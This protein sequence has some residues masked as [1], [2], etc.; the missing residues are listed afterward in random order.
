MVSCC[1][2]VTQS[3]DAEQ[4]LDAFDAVLRIHPGLTTRLFPAPDTSVDEAVWLQKPTSVGARDVVVQR[5]F[6]ED[7]TH[8][9]I[10][11]E[12]DDIRSHN[13]DPREDLPLRGSVTPVRGGGILVLAAHHL[14]MDAL[15]RLLLVRA[16]DQELRSDVTDPLPPV[17]GIR[18]MV[19]REQAASGQPPPD[20]AIEAVEHVLRSVQPSGIGRTDVPRDQPADL[21]SLWLSPAQ[22]EALHRSRAVLGA[23]SYTVLLSGFLTELATRSDSTCPAVMTVRTRRVGR[24]LRSLVGTFADGIVIAPSHPIEPGTTVES[25]VQDIGSVLFRGLAAKN[26]LVDLLPSSPLLQR[27]LAGELGPVIAFQYLD[28]AAATNPEPEA[29]AR[30]WYRSETEINFDGMGLE[31]LHVICTDHGD[32]MEIGAWYPPGAFDAETVEHMLNGFI[33]RTIEPISPTSTA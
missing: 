28:I 14:V 19:A 15:S 26:N 13:L 25:V 17:S 2:E 6:S 12:L 31:T 33:S 18:D 9:I 4:I 21:V 32:S 16:L 1:I 29:R 27:Y 30:L 5:P 3:V 20:S 11:R 7:P 22:Y 23:T 24:A 8:V 10:R